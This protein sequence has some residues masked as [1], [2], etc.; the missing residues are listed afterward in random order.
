M[1][2]LEYMIFL[3]NDKKDNLLRADNMFVFR[4]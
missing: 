4:M 3:K 1:V 2:Q